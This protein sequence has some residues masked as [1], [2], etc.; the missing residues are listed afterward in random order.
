MNFA[1]M[2]FCNDFH[3]QNGRK[4]NHLSH[5]NKKKNR[6]ALSDTPASS[7]IFHPSNVGAI[8]PNIGVFLKMPNNRVSPSMQAMMAFLVMF[9]LYFVEMAYARYMGANTNTSILKRKA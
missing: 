2:I 9:H 4:E 3:V 5:E 8:Q 1:Q 6:H 7:I